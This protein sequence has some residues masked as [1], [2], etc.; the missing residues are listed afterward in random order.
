MTMKAI[1]IAAAL[2]LAAPTAQAQSVAGLWDAQVTV[3]AAA[4][5]FAFSIAQTKSGPRGNFFDGDRPAG[6]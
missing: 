2:T 6:I 4:V 1:L 3:G 5:P